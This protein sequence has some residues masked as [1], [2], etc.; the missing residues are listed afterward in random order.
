MRWHE[1]INCIDFIGP[2]NCNRFN[3]ESENY[4]GSWTRE[5]VY[6]ELTEY[7]NLILLSEGEAD[8]LVV[9]E[10]L[11]CGLGVILSETSSK[12]LETT[13]FITI[14][15]DAKLDDLE[16]IEK[17]I[18]SNRAISKNKRVQIR[19]YGLKLYDSDV[20][21]NKYIEKINQIN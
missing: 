9:K 7:G 2:K 11:C 6:Q 14:I 17:Q 18:E 19:E 13:D 10:A 1:K 21:C 4:L 20:I 12:N 3:F 16:Y 8:P 5:Q 15:P